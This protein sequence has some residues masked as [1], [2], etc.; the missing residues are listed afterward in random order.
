VGFASQEQRTGA[1]DNISV[2]LSS[3]DQALNDVIVVGYG[4]QKK[5]TLTGAVEQITSKAF[6]SRAVTNVGLALQGQTPGLVVTRGSAR[7]GRED[8]NL[9]I[10]GATSVN[11]GSPLIVVDGVPTL[12]QCNKGWCYRYLRIERC[13]WCYPGYNK[14]GRRKIENR[15]QW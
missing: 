1:R 7:P 11:G 13:K 4:R 10:R 3:D 12:N 2:S 5:A 9:Q 14:K 8:L 15:L 6:E